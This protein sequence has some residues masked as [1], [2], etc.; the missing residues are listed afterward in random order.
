MLAFHL[1]K[2]PMKSVPLGWHTKEVREAEARSGIL[3]DE[4]EITETG[5]ICALL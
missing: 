4:T 1:Q 5:L 3:E 2:M